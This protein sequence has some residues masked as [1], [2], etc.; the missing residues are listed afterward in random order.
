MGY[1][2]FSFPWVY[3]IGY[4]CQ[5]IRA[6]FVRLIIGI[7][8]FMLFGLYIGIVYWSIKRMGGL[9]LNNS[10]IQAWPLLFRY[11]FMIKELPSEQGTEVRWW[12]QHY[13]EIISEVVSHMFDYS[14]ILLYPYHRNYCI[15]SRNMVRFIQIIDK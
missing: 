6:F 8:I 4:S 9:G 5:N 12:I 1:Q 13:S 3:F 15:W 11:N 7:V 2:Y 10:L 14:R